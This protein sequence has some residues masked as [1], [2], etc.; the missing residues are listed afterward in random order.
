[1]MTLSFLVIGIVTL[2]WLYVLFYSV[3]LLIQSFFVEPRRHRPRYRQAV[4]SNLLIV[5][6]GIL[7]TVFLLAIVKYLP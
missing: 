6:A 2:C 7:I 4:L 1:M 3:K 5:I